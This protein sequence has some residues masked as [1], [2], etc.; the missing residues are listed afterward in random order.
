MGKVSPADYMLRF[1]DS[2]EAF[3]ASNP[4]F[5]SFEDEETQQKAEN[6]SWVRYRLVS[7]SDVPEDA[8]AYIHQSIEKTKQTR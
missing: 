7:G 1:G 3:I 8:P 4:S 5:Q 2:R 6:S